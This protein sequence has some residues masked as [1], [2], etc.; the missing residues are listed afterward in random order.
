MDRRAFIIIVGGGL[1]TMPLAGEAQPVP[2][3]PKIG[4]L[5]GASSAGVEVLVEAFKQGMQEHGYVEGKTFVLEARYGDNKSERLPELARELVE[6]KVDVIVA[7]TDGPIAVARRETRT[8]PIV[9][10]NSTDPVGTGFVASLARPG[11]NVTGMSNISADLS[12]KRLSF[13]E[14]SCPGSPAWRFYGTPTPGG[15]YSTTRIGGGRQLTPSGASI[16][17]S[18]QRRRPRSCILGRDDWA[19]AGVARATRQSHRVLE[20]IRDCRLR[21]AKSASVHVWTQGICRR[22]GPHVL[23]AERGLR[24]PSIR[25]VCGQDPQRCETRRA[26]RAATDEVRA[27]D[28]SQ[29]GEGARA[30]DAA[31]GARARGSAYS[32]TSCATTARGIVMLIEQDWPPHAP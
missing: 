17:R 10:A 12:G 24:I 29:D 2:K 8:I 22:R 7:T 11:G 19:R 9:M 23:W 28:Q 32:M 30:D 21:A 26:A 4:L 31:V 18:H 6:R 20:A 14:K 27:R 5:S 3:V 1:I 25:H 16:H 15:P 13:S